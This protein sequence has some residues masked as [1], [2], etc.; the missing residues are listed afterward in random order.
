MCICV[1]NNIMINFDLCSIFWQRIIGLSCDTTHMDI[2]E[3]DA[4]TRKYK[5]IEEF[6]NKTATMIVKII[7]PTKHLR[8]KMKK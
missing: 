3:I 2:E 8:K 4:V 5:D 7:V 6:C 1:R